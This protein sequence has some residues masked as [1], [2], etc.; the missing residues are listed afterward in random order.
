MAHASAFPA[1]NVVS[2]RHSVKLPVFVHIGGF[3]PHM[4]I[5]T[6]G[7][8]NTEQECTPKANLA[9]PRKETLCE[10]YKGRWWS[11]LLR[12]HRKDLFQQNTALK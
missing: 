12:P 4:S 9:R 2:S 10:D 11:L 7:T 3:A 1:L 5:T 6:D 8:H